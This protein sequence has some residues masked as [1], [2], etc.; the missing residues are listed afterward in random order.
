MSETRDPPVGNSPPEDDLRSLIA[1]ITR[2]N[3]R[4]S[5]PRP[6]GEAEPAAPDPA[7]NAGAAAKPAGGATEAADAPEAPEAAEDRETREGPVR[8][9]GEA[10]EPAKPTTAPEH[11]N[12]TDRGDFDALPSEAAKA[13][14]LAMYKRMEGGFGRR[15]E[16]GAQLERDYGELDQ[17]FTPE[18]RNLLAQKNLEPK[19][20]VRAWHQIELGVG[21]PQYQDGWFSRIIGG[22]SANRA[23]SI[24]RVIHELGVDP[25]EI[26]GHLNQLRGFANPVS[27]YG[28]SPAGN[29][30]DGGNVVPMVDPRLMARLEA[31]ETD[32][33]RQRAAA[34]F[35]AKSE[36]QREINTWTAETDSDGN[37]LHPYFAEV[38]D[39]MMGLA[40]L[41]RAQGRTP[42]LN[43]LYDRAVWANKAIREKLQASQREAEDRSL[44]AARKAKADAAARAG[45][46]ITG[47]PSPGQLPQRAEPERSIRDDIRLQLR[48]AR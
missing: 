34:E 26:A 46:S 19:S 31:L 6:P 25:G 16:R 10:Q 39:A 5:S 17:I 45:A 40:Q 48:G 7:P 42:V 14:F 29:A 8:A 35:Q 18:Q 20:V 37:L 15:L 2:D 22:Y 23:V 47:A 30:G 41:D 36:A 9:T 3:V 21:S 43:D 32:Q 13:S 11:W 33:Q 38:E 24:A 1:G 28:A 4:S 44:A 12:A 27:G